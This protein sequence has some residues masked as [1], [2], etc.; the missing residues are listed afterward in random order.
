MHGERERI[1]NAK[2]R[3]YPAKETMLQ[4]VKAD[5]LSNL[6]D[7]SVMSHILRIDSLNY[8]EL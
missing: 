3:T 5:E 7:E 4:T 8:C 2:Y 6:Q 1:K